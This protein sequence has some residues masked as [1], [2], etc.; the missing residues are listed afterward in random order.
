MKILLLVVF[1]TQLPIDLDLR[2]Y[3]VLLLYFEL[4]LVLVLEELE[5]E[6]L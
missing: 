4:L 1:E 6:S 5:M 3:F 2:K